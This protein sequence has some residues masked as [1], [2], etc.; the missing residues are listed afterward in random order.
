MNEGKK[1]AL[2]VL[3]NMKIP[4]GLDREKLLDIAKTSLRTKVHSKIAS[5]LTEVSFVFKIRFL[6]SHQVST[7]NMIVSLGLRRCCI[8]YQRHKQGAGSSYDRNN[9][10]AT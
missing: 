6:L 9:G 2:E 4:V 1:K 7:M 5:I 10:N 8:I 3:E